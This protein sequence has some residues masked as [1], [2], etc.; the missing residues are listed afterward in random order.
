MNSKQAKQLKDA[1]FP[2]RTTFENGLQVAIPTTKK[3]IQYLDTRIYLI[4]FDDEWFYIPTLSELIEA[5]GKEFGGLTRGEPDAD[6]FAHNNT[7]SDDEVEKISKYGKT[8][9][10]AVAKLWL[11][12]NE[13]NEK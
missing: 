13:Q 3:I 4:K 5:C 9:E 8:P 12:L 7:Q 10:E 1:G 2:F 11:K 6:W